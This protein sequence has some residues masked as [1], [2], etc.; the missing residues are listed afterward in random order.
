V[1]GV[2]GGDNAV[3][4]TPP[5]V[6]EWHLD[7]DPGHPEVHAAWAV[8]LRS[9]LPSA[10]EAWTDLMPTPEWT[11]WGSLP[12]TARAAYHELLASEPREKKN[13]G[14]GAE[15]V[16]DEHGVDLLA[17]WGSHSIHTEVHAHAR[18]TLLISHDEGYIHGDMTS[19]EANRV[20]GALAAAGITLEWRYSPQGTSLFRRV[21]E[22]LTSR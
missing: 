2:S 18:R 4:E 3:A 13:P 16:L 1:V 10:V 12:Q 14:C 9:A 5:E 21:L 6:H 19:E 15:V 11:Q 22:R 7:G 8:I 17:A 20:A